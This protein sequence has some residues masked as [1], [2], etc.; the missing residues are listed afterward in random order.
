MPPIL[1]P[2]TGR[3]LLPGDHDVT[4]CPRRQEARNRGFEIDLGFQVSGSEFGRPAYTRLMYV[5]Q[6][7]PLLIR[8][9]DD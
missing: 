1:P 2:I 3:L 8:T 7:S 4:A 9:A 6:R 5:V